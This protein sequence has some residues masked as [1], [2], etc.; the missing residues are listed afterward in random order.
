MRSRYVSG[1]LI[2]T[3]GLVFCMPAK[4]QNSGKIVSNGTIAGVIV[5]VAAGVAVI[6]IV[7]IH[8]SKKRSITGCVKSGGSGLTFTDEK[9][10]QVYALSGETTGIKPG[11]RMKLQGKKVKSR[12]P[13][14]PLEWETKKVAKDFGV[15]QPM[16]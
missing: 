16:S 1:V 13:N 2:I 7:A 10:K 14:N 9:D 8:Y 4:A 12:D 3:L 11:D 5:G 15:C 6:A